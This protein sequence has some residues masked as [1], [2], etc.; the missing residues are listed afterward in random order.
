MYKY[1]YTGIESSFYTLNAP[2]DE[3]VFSIKYINSVHDHNEPNYTFV[4]KMD[5]LMKNEF[6][7]P[8]SYRINDLTILEEKLTGSGGAS[9]FDVDITLVWEEVSL[10]GAI[11][12]GKGKIVFHKDIPHSSFPNYRYPA[13]EIAFEFPARSRTMH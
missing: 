7:K 9:Y 12:S 6:F 10:D 2:C 4:M 13:Q 1:T 3:S 8:G 5:P 11:Y